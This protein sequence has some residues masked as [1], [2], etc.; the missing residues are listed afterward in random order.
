MTRN[1]VRR[2]A[3]VLTLASAAALA[4][5]C[6]SEDAMA[7]GTTAPATPTPTSVSVVSGGG[8]SATVDQALANPVV[9]Q[10]NDQFSNP[11]SNIDVTFSVTQGS[12]GNATAIS[13]TDGRASTTWTLGTTAGS[14]Q[15][16]AAVA[17]N[18]TVSTSISAMGTADVA[19]S[20]V[21]VSGDGQMQ[22]I[23]AAL[24]NDIVVRV[25]DQFG[26]PVQGHGVDFVVTLGTGSLNVMGSSVTVTTDANGEAAAQWTLGPEQPTQTVE[27]RATGLTGTPV[28]FS[29]AVIGAA[30]A[31]VVVS[32]GDTQTGLVNA[33]V[34]IA[35]AVLVEDAAGFPFPGATVT[36]AVA[37][38]GG[39]ASGLIATTNTSGIATVGGWTLGAAASANTLTATVTGSGITGSPV[40]FN[41]TGITPAF[42]IEVRDLSGFTATQQNA[43]NAA[44][45]KWESLII[46]DVADQV[47]NVLA[48]G[49]TIV[50]A[51]PAVMG[52]I[53]DLVILAEIVT[54][55]GAFGILGQAGPC[56]VR[57]GNGLPY[58]GGMQ[59]DVDDVTRLE[60]GRPARR[61]NSS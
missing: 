15:L 51:H 4:A 38:G 6:P 29:A 55:D 41:A 36:F 53:D 39:M 52:T 47:A 61:R 57:S 24:P 19:D 8:Q 26:N 60:G 12:V 43:F 27:A 5:A 2:S 54:I 33:P 42:N 40:T 30:P 20:L 58:L 49:C 7:P 16:A 10:V 44:A 23:N 32:A 13:A 56:F 3:L 46:G 50:S 18:T 21:Q 37:S 1:S 45:T 35:P 31:S 34:N 17:S 25:A 9:I 14:Q 11:M 28:A 59:F 48:D 22:Q